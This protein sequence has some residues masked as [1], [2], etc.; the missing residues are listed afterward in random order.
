MGCQRMLPI[1]IYTF[2]IA[3]FYVKY[4]PPTVSN[5]LSVDTGFF[6]GGGKDVLHVESRPLGGLG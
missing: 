6:S 1:V 3:D 5:P 2:T 4:Y